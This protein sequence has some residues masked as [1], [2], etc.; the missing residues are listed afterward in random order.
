MA[1]QYANETGY[2]MGYAAQERQRLVEQAAIYGPA[3][4]QVFLDAGIGPGMRV[5]D[6][7]CGVGDVSLLAAELVGPD[8]RVVGVDTDPLALGTARARAREAGLTT[9]D[10]RQGDLYELAVDEPFDAAVGR[11]ILLH[12]RNPVEAVRRV[13]RQVRPGGLV[14]F[15]EVAGA[16]TPLYY[17]SLPLWERAGTWLTE[18]MRRAGIELQM[19][20]RLY[21]VFQEAGLPAPALRFDTLVGTG[22]DSPLY[23]YMAHTIRSLLP[24]M[25]RLGIATRDEVAVETLGERLRDEV[26]AARGVVTWAPLVGAWTRTPR[27]QV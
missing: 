26:V 23:Q 13:A 5:L 20:L 8:G 14:A 19:G 1:T 16:N 24:L 12:V 7:G 25:E 9:V 21:Q 2:A 4:R 3:T 27:S 15:Q 17:P 10:F 22:P 6:V 18:T 11:V